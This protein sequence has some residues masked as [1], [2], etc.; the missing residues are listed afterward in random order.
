M[1]TI[2]SL[3]LPI[4]VA[5]VGVFFTSFLMWMVLPHHKKDWRK[6]PDEGGLRDA[7]R[8][9][10]AEP[11]QYVFPCAESNE[12]M[13]DPEFRKRY[14]AGPSGVLIIRP[15]GG[16][17][18]GKNMAKSAT[19]NLA[20]SVCVAYVATF[21][22][23]SA[24][25][26]MEIFRLTGTVAFLSY[27]AGLGWGAIWWGRLWSSTFKEMADGLAYGVVTGLAFMVLWP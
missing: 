18:I 7:L 23:E 6:V 24:S 14:A 20:V 5:T 8:S 12:Q 9:Q 26:G 19:F 10:G 25:T 21:A 17:D 27:A 15:T 13:K 3:W 2:V 4:I 22:L 1:V 16:F 11:G